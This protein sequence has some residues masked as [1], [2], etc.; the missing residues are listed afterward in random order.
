MT[1][2]PL[3]DPSQPDPNALV[4]PL[5]NLSIEDLMEQAEA[6]QTQLMEA[7]ARSAEAE[8]TGTAGNGAVSVTVTGG[9]DF[10]AL[11]IKP[12]IVD[13]TDVELLEDLILAALHDAVS[14]AAQVN[15]EMMAEFGLPSGPDN[16]GFGS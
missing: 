2:Y 13:P 9:M 14:K 15:Q 1:D 10:L 6:M 5:A 16:M 11:K 4:N 3:V 12:E 7:Q 8:V